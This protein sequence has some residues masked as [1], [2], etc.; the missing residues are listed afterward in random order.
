MPD[1]LRST[2][3][4]P[5]ATRAALGPRATWSFFLGV[6]LTLLSLSPGAIGGMGYTSAN[7]A[8]ANQILAKLGMTSAGTAA[9]AFRIPLHGVLEVGLEL[10]FMALGHLTT[11]I[12]IGPERALSAEPVLF[13]ALLG[14][15]AFVWAFRLAGSRVWALVIGLSAVFATVL[16]PYAYIGLETSQSL[17]LIAAAYIALESGPHPS[18]P[19]TLAVAVVGGLA[20]SLKING[21]FLVPAV[22][23]AV[24]RFVWSGPSR[25]R[26]TKVAVITT[27]MAAIFV[28][29]V[30]LRNRFWARYGGHFEVFKGLN[31]DGPVTWALVMASLLFSVNKGFF[32]FSPICGVGMA[33]LRRAIAVRKD[34]AVFVLLA[35]AGLLAGL[36]L[37]V[38]WA[39]ETWGARYL[40]GAVVPVLMLLAASRAG[41]PLRP[42]REWPLIT[43]V[44]IGVSI[45]F[46]GCF[47]FYGSVKVAAGRTKSSTLENLIYNLEYNQIRFNAKLFSLWVKRLAGRGAASEPWVP[48]VHWWYERPADTRVLE[49]V[50]IAPSFVPQPILLRD[51]GSNPTTPARVI[52]SAYFLFLCAG[53]WLLVGL[54]RTL[55][56]AGGEGVEERLLAGHRGEQRPQEAEPAS[57]KSVRPGSQE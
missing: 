54:S 56:K 39:D 40:H 44:I 14:T 9:E 37:F 20:V 52:W 29:N 42:R 33:G 6:F 16:W 38:A 5:E 17:C 8:A 21:V 46:L 55:L 25:G 7:M 49:P 41:Q 4:A 43:A 53:V 50:D 31:V 51:L 26:S 2:E 23:F 18:W 22:A 28:G 32:V 27:L 3:A 47:A 48:A 13:T 15:L 12:G 30:L 11:P 24:F 10:P 35:L 45:S 19:R 1:D 57:E 36:S 34:V